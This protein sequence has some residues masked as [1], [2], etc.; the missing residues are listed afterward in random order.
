MIQYT[1]LIFTI[2]VFIIVV[3]IWYNGNQPRRDYS[4]D[5]ETPLLLL[6]LVAFILIWGGIFWW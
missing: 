6:V 3:R 1:N 5:L 4:F 2:I